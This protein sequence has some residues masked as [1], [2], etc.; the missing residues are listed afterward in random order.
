MQHFCD[1][2]VLIIKIY[3]HLTRTYRHHIKH[4]SE[5]GTET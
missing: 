4:L 5:D 1:F 3:T 2:E